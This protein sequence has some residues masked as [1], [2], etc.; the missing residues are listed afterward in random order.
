MRKLVMIPLLFALSLCAPVFASTEVTTPSARVS[1][2]VENVRQ[3]KIDEDDFL[4][5]I[6]ANGVIGELKKYVKDPNKKVREEVF[7]KILAARRCAVES[8]DKPSA[9]EA[10]EITLDALK[11]E[12]DLGLRRHFLEDLQ[13]LPPSAFSPRAKK[14]INNMLQKENYNPALIRLAGTARSLESVKILKNIAGYSA[15]PLSDS[16]ELR[17]AAVTALASLGEKFYIQV[18]LAAIDRETD[19]LRLLRLLHEISLTRQPEAVQVLCKYT[20]SQQR[21]PS[22][23]DGLEGTKIAAYV[24]DYLSFTA[25]DVP[26]ENGNPAGNTNEDIQRVQQW[27]Q[28]VGVSN[29]LIKQ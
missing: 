15:T 29:I 22:V 8:G 13:F 21:V 25:K 5:V 1:S 28:K 9:N 3:G 16:D 11:G 19:S 7:K 20:F 14:A 18:L 17:Q 27:I 24:V 6:P 4:A 23:I 26:I 10:V 12:K 2:Y